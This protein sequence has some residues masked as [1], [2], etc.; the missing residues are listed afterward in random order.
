MG[1]VYLLFVSTDKTVV[2]ALFDLRRHANNSW[3]YKESESQQMNIFQVEYF[4]GRAN[5]ALFVQTEACTQTAR[6][7]EKQDH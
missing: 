5:T 7:T 6:E 3:Q 1:N 2:W 4:L